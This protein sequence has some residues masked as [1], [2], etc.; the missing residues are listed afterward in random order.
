MGFW[1]ESKKDMLAKMKRFNKVWDEL[2]LPVFK[3]PP[4]NGYRSQYVNSPQYSE[5]EGGYFVLVNLKRVRMPADYDFPPHVAERPRDFK[6][7]WFLIKEVGVA[8]IPPT[9]RFPSFF[10]QFQLNSIDQAPPLFRILHRRERAHCRK[11]SP[12]RCVQKRRCTRAS[13]GE[14][15]GIEQ[16]YCG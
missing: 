5:P 12:V 3:C 2:G 9:G 8:A 1:D 14:A 4:L 10:I 11:L 16:V 6:L 15:E 13:E 7:S